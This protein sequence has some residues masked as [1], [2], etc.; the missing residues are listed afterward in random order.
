MAKRIALIAPFLAHY[1]INFY[2]KLRSGLN[3]NIIFF[4][5][6]KYYDDGR[7][8]V[9][10]EKK[11]LFLTYSNVKFSIGSVKPAFSINLIKQ[12]KENNIRILIIEGAT[13]NLTSWY[14]IIF[15]KILGLK[16]ITWACGWQPETHSG[17]V[18]RNKKY[19]EKVFFNHV[20]C[21][22]SYSTT[23]QEYFRSIGIRKPITVAFNGI[24]TE[25]FYQ[26]KEEIFKSAESLKPKNNQKTF[27][28]VGGLFREKKVD[29]LIECFKGFHSEHADTRLWIIGSGPL[30]N[31]LKENIN[32]DNVRNIDFFGRVEKGVEKYFAAAD[33]LVLPGVGGLALNQAMLWG[34]PCIVSE[35]DGTENDL[36]IDNVTGF[37]F[38]KGDRKSLLEA[39]SRAISM[40]D[41][42]NREMS[43]KAQLLILE[44]SNTDQMVKTFTEVIKKF[45]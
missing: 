10:V 18:K 6:N 11:E 42:E 7:P 8:G 28:Y 23:T 25:L 14:F 43:L 34:K 2:E 3:D 40:T 20:D 44:R 32:T 15:R 4:F 33:F 30:L 29:F 13:S 31:E 37:R 45:L 1:R 22:I 35:A 5:Q 27:L 26:S 19:F 41:K 36:V 9:T 24:D 21:I 38:N 16:I 17:I 12:I 39:M